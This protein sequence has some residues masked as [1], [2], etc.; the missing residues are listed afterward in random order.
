MRRLRLLLPWWLCLQAGDT[1]L[2]PRGSPADYPVYESTSNSTIAAVRVKSEQVA[3]TLSTGI[4][5]NYVVVEVAVYPEGG[6]TVDVQYSDFAL[7]F[8]GRQETFPVTP[9][10][11]SVPWRENGGIKDR[12]Q[13]TTETGVIVATQKDPVNGR[14]TSVGTYERVGVAVGNPGPPDQPPPGPDPSVVEERLQARALPQGKT[15][16]AIAGYVYFPRPPKNP[17]DNSSTLVYF[18]DGKSIDLTLPVK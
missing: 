5:R 4:D 3:K 9:K 8:A 14:Q 2:T 13:V 10:E 12:V 1:G 6:A 15:S 16:K 17:K 18:K 11:A 7:R